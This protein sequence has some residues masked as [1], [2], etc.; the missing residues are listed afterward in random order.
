MF[1]RVL[2]AD[3][4]IIPRSR[5]LDAPVAGATVTIRNSATERTAETN[6]DGEFRFENLPPGEYAVAARHA[7]Y[8]PLRESQQVNVPVRGCVQVLPRLNAAA[9][10]ADRALDRDGKPA[11]RVPVQLLRRNNAGEWYAA[12]RFQTTS[13]AKGEFK[14]FDLPAGDYLLGH[15][16]WYGKPS[17]KTPYPT[18]YY[19]GV[20][21]RGRAATLRLEPRQIMSGI[22]LVLPEPHTPRRIRVVVEWP[23]G[24]PPG[25]NLVQIFDGEEQLSH[26]WGKSVIDLTGYC[27]RTH[28]LHAAYTVDETVLE[29]VRE[30]A[31]SER[32]KPAPGCEPAAVKLVLTRRAAAHER[33]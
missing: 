33:D 1:G 20:S 15:E 9:G 25:K 11:P 19:P 18:H 27:E 3:P 4:A 17:I 23:G 10:I 29:E 28:D 8:T 6:R 30:R 26:A 24:E 16:I 14:F 2:Q 22:D 21:V 31:L 12:S 13:S 7:A 5:H 32:V